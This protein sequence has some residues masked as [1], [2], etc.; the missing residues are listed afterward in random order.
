MGSHTLTATRLDGPYQI[1]MSGSLPRA[2]LTPIAAPGS[3]R[4]FAIYA[5]GGGADVRLPISLNTTDVSTPALSL[6]YTLGGTAVAGEHFTLLSPQPLSMSA[7]QPTAEILI[8]P[9]DAGGWHGEKELTVTASASSDT[10]VEGYPLVFKV[11][12]R[13][14]RS[15]PKVSFSTGTQSVVKG[16]PATLTASLNETCLDDITLS[17]RVDEAATTATSGEYT[18]PDPAE[19]TVLAN[20]LTGTA[21]V[22]TSAGISTER[23]LKLDVRNDERTAQANLWTFSETWAEEDEDTTQGSTQILYP[24]HAADGL[25]ANEI[26]LLTD[27]ANPDSLGSSVMAV[28]ADGSTATPYYT[29]STRA[30]LTDADGNSAAGANQRLTIDTHNLFSVYVKEPTSV[31]RRSEYFALEL[32]DRTQSNSHLAVWQWVAG[33][34]VLAS[35]SGLDATTGDISQ[36][37]GAEWTQ[38]ADGTGWYRVYLY[39]A[40]TSVPNTSKGVTSLTGDMGHFIERRFYPFY[41]GGTETVET[42]AGKG[43]VVAWPMFERSATPTPY[44]AIENQW[45]ES[46]LG[47]VGDASK[48]LSH[49]VTIT[50]S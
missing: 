22:T 38:S 6:N 40:G 45:W 25:W 49:T 36:G 26:S 23:T 35:S 28:V 48:P 12:I 47:A 21:S 37:Q 18:L 7:G 10:R 34:P 11:F 33:V 32:Q 15:M 9:L 17:F 39:Y 31:S 16:N 27:G 5:Q 2:S 41:E 44:Q 20:A 46:P 29:K 50:L 19:V 14:P 1:T 43:T 3:E 4:Y 42:S 24:A 13:S 8:R 30:A